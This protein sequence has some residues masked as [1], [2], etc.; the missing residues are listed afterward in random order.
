MKRTHHLIIGAGIAGL[1][2][3]YHLGASASSTVVLEK[4]NDIGAHAST[5]NSGMIHHYHPDR[6]MRERIDSG[7]QRLRSYEQDASA[8]FFTSAPSYFLFPADRARELERDPE[9]WGEREAVPPG[10]VPASLKPEGKP[11]DA[12][13]MRF[14]RD[15]LIQP[16]RYLLSLREDLTRRQIDLHLDQPVVDGAQRGNHWIVETPSC[17]YKATN[18]INAAGAWAERLGQTLGTS[19]KGL[20]A[21]RRHLYVADERILP[22]EIGFYWDA[23]NGIYFRHYEGG[24]LISNCDNHDVPPGQAPDIEHP[25]SLLHDSLEIYYPQFQNVTINEY[26]SCHRTWGPERVPYITA[27]DELPGFY[28]VAGLEGHGITASMWIGKHACDVITA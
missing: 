27:D 3:A 18:L 12:V 19:P 17:T 20:D 13:W 25:P 22:D 10:D 15:G 28:W 6:D 2:T 9:A 23:V 1:S 5:K 8:D 4:E 16:E 21:Y 26:W 7:V 14:E 11:S 24:T